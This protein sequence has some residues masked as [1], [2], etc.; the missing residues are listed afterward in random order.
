MADLWKIYLKE[1]NPKMPYQIVV[2]KLRARYNT[3]Y[4]YL[5]LQSEFHSLNFGEFMARIRIQDGKEL[6]RRMVEYLNNITPQLVYSFHT[7]SNKIRYLH[8]A[9]LSMKWA[10]TPLKNISMAQYNFN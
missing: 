5:S 2:D 7:E 8:N 6:L 9:V 3:P 4:R 10:T 1:I